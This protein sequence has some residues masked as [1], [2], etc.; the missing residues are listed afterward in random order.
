MTDEIKAF[1]STVTDIDLMGKEMESHRQQAETA[2]G[3]NVLAAN[4]STSSIPMHDAQGKLT[5]EF[6]HVVTTSWKKAP[7][8]PQA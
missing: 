4:M 7:A 2:F 3:G 8:E 5:G 1:S 6:T